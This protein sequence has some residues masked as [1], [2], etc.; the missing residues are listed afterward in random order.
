MNQSPVPVIDSRI[1]GGHPG[2]DGPRWQQSAL[3]NYSGQVV[4]PPLCGVHQPVD[5][6]LLLG[7]VNKM[8]REVP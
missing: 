2:P 6:C 4:D 3:F 1:L 8:L 5:G 7:Q